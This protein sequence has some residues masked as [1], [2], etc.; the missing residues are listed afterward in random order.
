[1]KSVS[2]TSLPA[3]DVER[4]C[5]GFVADFEH[6]GDLLSSFWG[7]GTQLRKRRPA[8]AKARPLQMR[9]SQRRA[10]GKCR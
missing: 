8:S 4:E 5:G 1:M 3:S 9:Y 2:E 10:C 6:W 7:N